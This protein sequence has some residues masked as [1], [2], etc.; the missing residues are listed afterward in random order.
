MKAKT[1]IIF[2][3]LLVST[4]FSNSSFAQTN[5]AMKDWEIIHQESGITLY[6][7]KENCKIGNSKLPNVYAFVKIVNDNTVDKTVNFTF[8]LQYEEECNGCSAGSE[9]S[10]KQIVPSNSSIEADCSFEN[11][12]LSRIISNPNLKGGWNFQAI[13]ITNILID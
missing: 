5:E 9:F 2:V 4:I 7:K 11:S 10:I 6:A 13:K 3:T 1:F 12:D 8:G